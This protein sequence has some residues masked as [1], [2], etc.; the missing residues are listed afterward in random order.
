MVAMYKTLLLVRIPADSGTALLKVDCSRLRKIH[1]TKLRQNGD[2]IRELNRSGKD[3]SLGPIGKYNFSRTG[4]VRESTWNRTR[5][6]SSIAFFSVTA[7]TLSV[8]GTCCDPVASSNSTDN[9][10]TNACDKSPAI[11]STLVRY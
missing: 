3:T 9:C 7:A 1:C 4:M 8:T 6:F 5:R 11:E 10:P 2:T